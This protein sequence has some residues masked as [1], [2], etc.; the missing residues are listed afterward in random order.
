M[1]IFFKEE[2]EGQNKYVGI[3]CQGTPWEYWLLLRDM[4]LQSSQK[5][6]FGFNMHWESLPVSL[7]FLS[8]R[9]ISSPQCMAGNR[10]CSVSAD[11][12]FNSLSVPCMLVDNT[13]TEVRNSGGKFNF[14]LSNPT[15]SSCSVYSSGFFS[16]SKF[17]KLSIW[18]RN[19]T[20]LKLYQWSVCRTLPGCLSMQ[21]HGAPQQDPCPR[22]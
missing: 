18:I 2:S 4:S 22:S 5:F 14:L 16:K 6:A 1:S 15:P 10:W 21:R 19:I 12:A 20:D 17:A 9:C 13:D 11:Q 8:P 3:L 7:L